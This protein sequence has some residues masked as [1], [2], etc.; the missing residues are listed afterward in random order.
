MCL[1]FTFDFVKNFYRQTE[2]I[3]VEW[4]KMSRYKLFCEKEK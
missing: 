1:I 3:V 2:K 4:L